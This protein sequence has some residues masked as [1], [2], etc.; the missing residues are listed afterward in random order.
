MQRRLSTP[1]N[2]NSILAGTIA[3]AVIASST[4]KPLK[5]NKTK[6]NLRTTLMLIIVCILF[7]ITEFPQAI[8]ILFS[9]IRGDDFYKNVY[10]PLG[11]LLDMLALLNNS[12]N[13]LLY[14]TMSRAFR[15]TFYTLIVNVKNCF[16]CFRQQRRSS[17]SVNRGC[18]GVSTVAN[19]GGGG[20]CGGGSSKRRVMTA[21]RRQ[22][23]LGPEESRCSTFNIQ[24]AISNT[25]LAQTPVVN[26]SSN[27]VNNI[28]SRSNGALIKL[29]GDDGEQKNEQNSR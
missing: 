29:N 5:R 28:N 17:A 23:L 12:I 4:G 26:N 10:M 6:E 11:D 2:G 19:G 27:L 16:G 8:L 18:N 20:G 24:P 7:L 15:N 3:S 14:C 22:Q 25:N 9:I 13:F 21:A 1:C